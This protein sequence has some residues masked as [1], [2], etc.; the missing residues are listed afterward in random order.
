M[1]NCSIE[2]LLLTHTFFSIMQFSFFF[3]CS[4]LRPTKREKALRFFCTQKEKGNKRDQN[5]SH[6][7]SLGAS[8]HHH[9]PVA[10]RVLFGN[11]KKKMVKVRVLVR[12]VSFLRSRE[13]AFCVGRCRRA[14]SVKKGTTKDAKRRAPDAF[15]GRRDGKKSTARPRE[16]SER[17]YRRHFFLGRRNN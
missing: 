5:S 9:Q 4:F 7:S 1:C 2:F 6:S 10:K 17:I 12:V 3:F 13:R 11:D 14:F 8:G 15:E 16:D